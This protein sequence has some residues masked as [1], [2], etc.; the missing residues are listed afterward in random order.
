MGDEKGF[1]G[2]YDFFYLPIV[3]QSEENH[4]YA[5][6]NFTTTENYERFR[7]HFSFFREWNMPSDNICAVTVSDKF[8]NLDD[9][10]KGYRDSPVM[11]ESV[12]ERFKP[13]LCENGQRL[14]FPEP[15]TK[16]K[17]PRCNRSAPQQ[18]D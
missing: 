14:P 16:I 7:E 3:F 8:S 6:I 15:T 5:F 9:Y 4:G 18:T 11:H 13:V 10:I 2:C 12:E 17:A 1:R